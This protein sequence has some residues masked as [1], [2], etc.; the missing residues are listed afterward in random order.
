MQTRVGELLS[1]RGCGKL[2]TISDGQERPHGEGEGW[3]E[4]GRTQASGRAEAGRPGARA[5]GLPV[6]VLP[7]PFAE[8]RWEVEAR[9]FSSLWLLS[10]RPRTMFLF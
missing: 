2:T 7:L 10:L 5:E 4:A 9:V 8:A 1:A 3:T 6:G